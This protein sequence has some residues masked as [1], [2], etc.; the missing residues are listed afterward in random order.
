MSTYKVCESSL[1]LVI[2][3]RNGFRNIKLNNKNDP[4]RLNE[5]SGIKCGA[6]KIA[7]VKWFDNEL[8][9]Y[10]ENDGHS[11]NSFNWTYAQVKTID[12]I[13]L[14]KWLQSPNAKGYLKE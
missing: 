2:N 10:I 13:G 9:K 12:E 5:I 3:M 6:L 11:F 7:D 1:R 14:E 8:N 4:V